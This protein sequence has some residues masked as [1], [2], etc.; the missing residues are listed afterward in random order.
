MTTTINVLDLV[1]DEDPDAVVVARAI[2]GGGEDSYREHAALPL[3]EVILKCHMSA[4]RVSAAVDRWVAAG[5]MAISTNPTFG[6]VCLMRPLPSP[7]ALA[8]SY[9][10]VRRWIA[11]MHRAPRRYRPKNRDPPT[12]A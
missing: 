9:I 6:V 1:A 4:Q 7:R 10:A 12:R 3:R 11:G 5:G 8:A 2:F